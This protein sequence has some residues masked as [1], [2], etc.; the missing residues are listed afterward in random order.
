MSIMFRRSS[1]LLKGA[2]KRSFPKPNTPYVRYSSS[3]HSKSNAPFGN[4]ELPALLLAGV[5]TLGTIYLITPKAAKR[6]KVRS[7]TQA[8]ATPMTTVAADVADAEE[9]GLS[10]SVNADGTVDVEGEDNSASIESEPS[11][12][13]EGAGAAQEEGSEEAGSHESAYNPDTGEINWDCS[14]LGG[15]A[16]GP[17]GE[18]FKAAFSC[19]VYSDADPKG[20]DCVEKFQLMQDCFRRYP[21]T[22][23]DQLKAEDEAIEEETGEKRPEWNAAKA[24]AIENTNT[25]PS[26]TETD[27]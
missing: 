15:M 26:S 8:A 14:C 2:L 19:F 12:P 1:F 16:H 22:Y 18:E 4:I 25:L 17:C 10:A 23:A 6:E 20:I 13:E 21:E 5:T 27:K 3:S 24:D 7:A 9:K 11:A